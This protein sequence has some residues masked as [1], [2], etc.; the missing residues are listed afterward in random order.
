MHATPPAIVQSAHVFS[1]RFL[2]YIKSVENA[3]KIGYKNGKWF[4]HPAPEGGMPEIGYGHKIQKGE[5]SLF[6]KGLSDSEVS[7]L[8]SKDLDIAKKRV[9]NDIKSMFHVNIP[10]NEIQEEI[11]TDYAFNL[12]TLKNYPKFVR[13][14]L[15]KD[16]NTVKKEYVRSFKDAKGTT[17]TLA[18]NKTFFNTYLKNLK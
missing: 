7:K 8:L 15:N 10:L 14:V 4:P 16:W 13:A 11:L 6:S 2:E 9:Y 5:E 1:S 17:H 3:S 12:G 18:R